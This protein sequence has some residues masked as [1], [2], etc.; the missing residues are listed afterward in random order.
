MIKRLT[1]WLLLSQWLLSA[2]LIVLLHA[3]TAL[4]LPIAALVAIA[5]IAVLRALIVINNFRLA[6]SH[7]R[8]NGFVSSALSLIAWL[9]LFASEY[10]ASMYSSSW[11]M[12]FCTFGA[13]LVDKPNGVP[14]LLIHGYGC[15]SG[16][17]HGMSKVL[18]AHGISHRA[19]D[20]E[21]VLGSI[22]AYVPQVAGAIQQLRTETNQNQIVL[23]GHS[24]GGLVARAYLACHADAGIVRVI[25][26]GTPHHGTGLADNA[27]GCNARQMRQY[28]I[29]GHTCPSD[30]LLALAKREQVWQ[31]R[32]I[33]SLYSLHDNIV[34]PRFSCHLE[35]ADNQAFAAVGHVALALTPQVQQQVMRELDQAAREISTALDSCTLG[36]VSSNK[37]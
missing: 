22:D 13:R 21:P 1:L 15:N 16:Y 25:T 26:L 11:T 33:V 4:S 20:L 6:A 19:L 10:A 31:R 9:H 23:L 18:L 7:E 29:N 27:P 17:W 8:A 30:W 2:G 35:G 24:M 5:T 3:F 28:K 36:F 32:R 37:K 12:A 14:V 34:A